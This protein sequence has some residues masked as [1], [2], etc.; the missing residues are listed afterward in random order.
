MLQFILLLTYLDSNNI[1]GNVSIYTRYTK[2]ALKKDNIV[3][4]DILGVDKEAFTY[5]YYNFGNISYNEEEFKRQQEKLGEL[6]YEYDLN[7]YLIILE[8]GI[9]KDSSMQALGIVVA[10]VIAIIIFTSVF[11]IKNSFNISI[12]EKIK[13]YGMLSTIGATSKQIKKNVYCEA[14]MLGV[15]GIPL[16]ILSGLLASYILIILS[17]FLIGESMGIELIYSFSWTSILFAILLGL[18]TLYLSAWGSARKASKITPITA[19][20]NSEDI[21]INSKKIKSPKYIKKIFGIGGEV[22]YK[23]LKRN[24]KKYRATV[25]SIIVCSSVFI[26]LSAFINL[27]FDYVKRDFE[28][29]DYNIVLSYRTDGNTNIKD[30]AHEVTKLDNIV[31]YSI[32]SQSNFAL[33]NNLV[34]F[35]DE[36]LKYYPSIL[37]PYT[38]ED[39]NGNTIEKMSST[40]LGVYK[41]GDHAYRKYLEKLGLDYD[42][43]KDKAIL[44]NK[45]KIM[46][47]KEENSNDYI[48]KTVPFFGYK[49]GDLLKWKKETAE[50]DENG[51]YITEEVNIELAELADEYPFGLKN[52][53]NRNMLILSDEQFD[54]IFSDNL[55]DIREEISIYSDNATIL[56]DEIEKILGDSDNYNLYNTEEQVKQM[57]SFY[58]LVA[59]FL[60][61]FITVIALIGITNIFN[62]IT[63]N[64]ELRSREFAT[65]KSIGMTKKEFNRM[66]SLE[67]FFY[68]TKSLI[69]GI[70]IGTLLAYLIHNLLTENDTTIKFQLPISAIL[71]ATIAVFILITFIMKYS[72]TKINKQN[73]IETI[74]NENI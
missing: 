59:I 46:V 5:L 66:I 54:K 51:E 56:Q 20:R 1:N 55:N 40:Y 47:P 39:E 36:Y 17:D 13:Q 73:T 52:L 25:I 61:G 27:A 11:C 10:V 30:K 50:V 4:A 6:K 15:V 19:I 45:T 3:T 24:K 69:I 9:F 22:S 65:L 34:K 16:G 71:I 37:D 62:T 72:I 18:V 2:D 60:Y 21:K 38:I 57:Q 53:E 41:V 74:R 26:A 68:G 23:N 67:S 49:K 28:S 48:E 33:E 29:T 70:P 12:T 44:I 64:M 63:T 58:L 42:K 8:T 43:T 31:D 7:D 35:S 14:L 32:V